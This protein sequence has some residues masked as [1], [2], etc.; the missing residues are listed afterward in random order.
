MLCIHSIGRAARPVPAAAVSCVC[1]L[2]PA[3]AD[4]GERVFFAATGHYY[5]RVDVASGI[6]WTEAQAATLEMRHLDLPG[7]LAT[8][9]SEEENRFIADTFLGAIRPDRYPETFQAWLGGFQPSG[10]PEP[11]G[12][13][14]WVTGEGFVFSNWLRRQPD[15]AFGDE[16][17]I[18]IDGPFGTR[19]TWSDL[20]SAWRL[21]AYIVEYEEISPPDPG[22]K[23]TWRF[24]ALDIPPPG[25]DSQAAR[26]RLGRIYV[27]L[28]KDP[29]TEL[30][31]KDVVRFEE[32]TRSW[33]LVAALNVARSF[34]A[35]AADHRSRIFCIGGRD[36]TVLDTVERYDPGEDQWTFVAPLPEPRWGA[37]AVADASGG[38]IFVL[39]GRVGG[40]ALATGTVL[41]YDVEE[42]NWT[43]APAMS[44]PRIF[45]GAALGA[46]GRIYAVGGSSG[47]G[48]GETGS[49]VERLDPENGWQ[50]IASLELHPHEVGAAIGDSC[51]FV[52]A[53]GGWD[54][55]SG[56]PSG[57]SRAVERYDP[58]RDRWDACPPLQQAKARLAV[59]ISNSGRM[60]AFGGETATGVLPKVEFTFACAP[61]V[62]S[63]MWK[64]SVKFILDAN[65]RRAELGRLVTDADVRN[66]IATAN[67]IL[68]AVGERTT[69][70]LADIVDVRDR[71]EH[72]RM[73]CRDH[74][75]TAL[76]R[77]AQANPGPYGWRS[78][79]INVYVVGQLSG[80]GG[81]CSFPESGSD[82][83]V[84]GQLVSATTLLHE[85]GHYFGL[86]HTQGC[87][88][89]SC[90]PGASG[91]CDTI[92]E[93][94]GIDDTLPD[95]ACWT[96]EDIAFESFGTDF[97]SLTPDEKTRV[98]DTFFN[99]MSYHAVDPE[100]SRLTPGQVEWMLEVA[101]ARAL[102]VVGLVETSPCVEEDPG[103]RGAI[104]DYFLRGD[105][106]DDGVVD[107]GDPV[108]SLNHLFGGGPEPP[109]ADAADANDD[110]V[111]D[112]ADPIFTFGF[113]F[114]GESSIP[115]PGAQGCG[116]D[117]TADELPRC[118]YNPSAC[119]EA[120]VD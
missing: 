44:H 43:P 94:D 27:P 101:G 68:C 63:T 51:G 16:N 112:L 17:A 115:S 37:Q 12:G 47:L 6:T 105:A 86:C 35:V 5:E 71:P 99:V 84:M 87:P 108:H 48:A 72:F 77:E 23:S 110:A 82:I 113:L 24:S 46:D 106:N 30:A 22:N 39:G 79:A 95:L 20:S 36:G 88:C 93:D 65:G 69:L 107:L 81:L 70:E 90:D 78:D 1:A 25:G 45:F 19:G 73:L 49:T 111:L 42:N 31:R 109:C 91:F 100:R 119:P 28:G 58:E 102:G 18:C 103:D 74:E 3:V 97:E 96:R 11:D 10:S 120:P 52:Y 41:R 66:Q 98:D 26:D 29:E 38:S 4:G 59:A 34:S 118:V 64:V 75:K 9:S 60:Y 85:L 15:N 83:I 14:E 8:V 116:P 57:L 117:P 92:P 13:W 54:G 7:H 80:C 61:E 32:E 114:L 40:A 56:E 67:R 104:A 76:D 62:L 53:I 55:S 33:Q 21:T 2:L 89:G 50:E